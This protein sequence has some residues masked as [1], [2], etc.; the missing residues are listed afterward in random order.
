[1]NYRHLTHEEIEQL[2]IQK[3]WAED[4]QKV[5]VNERFEADRVGGVIFSGSVYLGA[6]RGKITLPSG[7]EHFSGIYN[8][9]LNDCVIGD[10]ACIKDLKACVRYEIAANTVVENV[11]YLVCD[12]EST[13][14]NGAVLEIMNEG[15][16]RDLPIFEE[17]NAQIA[18]LM[19]HY[20]HDP[21]FIEALNR[22]IEK[23]VQSK[24]KKRAQIGAHARISHCG[25]LRN[26]CVGPYATLERVCCLEEGTMV[27]ESNASVH[28]GPGVIAR[29]FI[30]QSGAKVS[31]GVQLDHCFVGQA[32][33]LGKQFSAENS[34]FFA[35][36]GC[37]HG[38]AVSVM[39]GPYTVSHHKSTLLI[40]AQFSFYN[41]GSGS[42]QSNHMYKIGPVHQGLLER[43]SKTGSFSYLLWPSRIAPFS[44]VLGKHENNIDG[45]A[46]PFSYIT[47]EGDR[48]VLTPAINLFSLGTFRDAAKWPQRDKR[49]GSERRD[50]IHFELY[51]PFIMERV[52]NAV[53]LLQKMYD[54]CDRKAEFVFHKGLAV[55]RL[56]LRK[57]IQYYNLLLSIYV[58]EQLAKR[59]TDQMETLSTIDKLRKILSPDTDH[60]EGSWLDINGMF[61]RSSRIVD[62]M[63]RIKSESITQAADLHQALRKIHEHYETDVWCWFVRW[64]EEQREL[65]F[66]SIERDELITLIQE[67]RDSAEKL[68]KKIIS[69]ASKE[70][71]RNSRLT[72]G[73]DGDDAVIEKD[74]ENVRGTLETQSFIRKLRKEAEDVKKRAEALLEKLHRIGE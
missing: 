32:V 74:F 66:A 70:F 62:L 11:D 39:A 6:F 7:I 63:E 5:F 60:A 42:N 61:C 49:G 38:E 30:I 24:R 29:H 54:N 22:L 18:Y 31:D 48:S 59:L 50:L 34:A 33:E 20:R 64:A 25:S 73:I 12:G 43:G 44:V 53:K 35:N 41:A 8:A 28:I 52:S 2:K 14:G 17:L 26:V 9:H 55:K 69:D 56:L 23:Q 21:D 51:S 58:G 65:D 3:C 45:A 71:D 10:E 27:S 68:N 37:F 57:G 46:F 19:V 47:R 1:M 72:Y 13:F 36:S 15:G 4:W 40:A 16:G 67:W